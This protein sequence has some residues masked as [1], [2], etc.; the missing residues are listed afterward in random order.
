MTFAYI[1]LVSQKTKL[2]ASFG[3][4][5]V[6]SILKQG[7]ELGAS[8]KDITLLLAKAFSKCRGLS[9][10]LLCVYFLF[11]TFPP[12]FSFSFFFWLLFVWW[13]DFVSV[14]CMSCLCSWLQSAPFLDNNIWF[15]FKSLI[16][17]KLAFWTLK[18][19]SRSY[20]S[21]SNLYSFIVPRWMSLMSLWD[22]SNLGLRC[23]FFSPPPFIWGGEVGFSEW[24]CSDWPI[25]IIF[26]AHVPWC[27]F[28]AIPAWNL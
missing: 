28:G 25:K 17:S 19:L 26:C 23:L 4:W 20:F 15:L 6:G 5:N 24:V 21:E 2:H 16:T 8:F 3:Y 9:V 1:K 11:C 7:A 22:E 10:E 27:M 12:M 14:F 13:S 18:L